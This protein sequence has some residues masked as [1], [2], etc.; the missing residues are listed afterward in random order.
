MLFGRTKL[1]LKLGFFVF[2]GLVILAI[3]VLSIGSVQ[4]WASGYRVNFVFNFANGIKIGAPVRFAGIDCGEVRS[5]NFSFDNKEQETK[6]N[7]ICWVKKEI[8]IPIDSTIWINTLGLLGEKYVEIMPGE[9]YKSVLGENQS[10][11]GVDPLPMHELVRSGKDI[12]D[13]LDASIKKIIAGEGTVGKL[14]YEERIYN[15]LEE[16][17]IDLKKNPWKLFWKQKEKK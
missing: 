12:I 5:I 7:V 2:I 1:E 8:K 17:I 6:V 13:N 16:M 4:T 15:E 14:L 3:F 9:N 11:A 10:L